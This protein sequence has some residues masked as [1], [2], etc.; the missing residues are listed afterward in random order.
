LSI[1]LRIL[2]S[3]SL[4]IS[5]FYFSSHRG[6]ETQR[7]SERLKVNGG[8]LYESERNI[9]YPAEKNP[10]TKTLLDLLAIF[11]LGFFGSFGHCVGMCGPLTVALTLS[12]RDSPKS[13]SILFSIYLNLGRILSY[14]IVGAV[15][16]SL[17]SLIALSSQLAGVG[18]VFRQSIVVFTGLLLIWCGLNHINPNLFPKIPIVQPIQSK[19][20]AYLD[21]LMNRLSNISNNSQGWKAGLLGILWGLIPC[22]FLYIA[23]IKAIETSSWWGGATTMLAFGLGTTPMM[24][25]VGVSSSRLSQERRSQLF[26]L[27]GWITLI[28]GI[29]TLFRSDA[30][31]DVTGYGSL[32]LLM[33]AL[34]A[35]P[36]SV[37]WDKPLLYRRAIGV[38][39][40]ILAVVHTAHM[41]DH[42]LAWNL[43][44][45]DFLIPQHR[46]G[47]LTGFIAL[48]L[49]LPAAITSSD[50]LQKILGKN[51][52]RI[53]LF[54]IPALILATFHSIA[55]GSDYLGDLVLN[56]HHWL[57][58]IV[59]IILTAVVLFV[60]I[61]GKNPK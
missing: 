58:A 49:I 42:S 60:R 14:G 8:S 47:I 61:V 56:W 15:L 37:W 4:G 28:I 18:S 43:S 23:Q 3:K 25:A 50:R 12:Q 2:Q 9:I 27:S 41:L 57:S 36:L 35:R 54:S 30:M 39:S 7:D 11:S 59:L 5:N 52:R 48:G 44:S 51:W 6:T 20:K 17:G 46:W 1:D 34:I 22:G 16:G 33:L 45:I 13:N 26:R 24:L 53:H 29:L 38:G 31:V 32:L 55:I 19:L 40:F 10:Q 21:R